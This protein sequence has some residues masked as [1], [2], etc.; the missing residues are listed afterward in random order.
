MIQTPE[1]LDILH[2]RLSKSTHL[3]NFLCPVDERSYCRSDHSIA[4]QARSS[5]HHTSNFPKLR[6][7]GRALTT[8]C[9]VHPRIGTSFDMMRINS[10]D[11]FGGD[12]DLNCT[13]QRY[14]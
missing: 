5:S 10:Q 14:Y 12:R 1:D 3:A 11:L 13:P 2:I 9:L 8:I 6:I 7:N 4:R